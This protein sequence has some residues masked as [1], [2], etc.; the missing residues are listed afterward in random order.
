MS[1]AVRLE[2]RGKLLFDRPT[3]LW[4]DLQ[5][6]MEIKPGN[7]L[8]GVISVGVWSCVRV[9]DQIWGAHASVHGLRSIQK[10]HII[11]F[12]HF[13]MSLVFRNLSIS[14][15]KS[16]DEISIQRRSCSNPLN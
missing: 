16:L 6:L 11:I 3:I 1:R 4:G 9:L 15:F 13:A 7:G 8:R 14:A 5:P 10:R 12:N 2:S